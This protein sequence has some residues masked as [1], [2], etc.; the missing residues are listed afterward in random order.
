MSFRI[1]VQNHQIKAILSGEFKRISILL[2]EVQPPSNAKFFWGKDKSE[3]VVFCFEDEGETKIINP[4]AFAGDIIHFQQPF[5]KNKNGIYFF[6]SNQPII[7]NKLNEVP[8]GNHP[9]EELPD[10][11]VQ[12]KAQIVGISLERIKEKTEGEAAQECVTRIKDETFLDAF[13]RIWNRENTIKV[14][15]NPFIWVYQFEAI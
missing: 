13:F 8:D 3:K 5:V 14:A 2:K 12:V 6:N 9:A 10:W 4:P 11:A 1:P 15:S 7:H